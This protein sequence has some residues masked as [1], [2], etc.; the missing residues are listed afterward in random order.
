MIAGTGGGTASAGGFIRSAAAGR[1][2][3]V[4]DTERR[5]L[6]S[7]LFT[8]CR[9]A[10]A[11]GAASVPSGPS[12]KP[13]TPNGGTQRAG[14]A[15]TV[16]LLLLL[17]LGVL[18]SAS[19]SSS[20][21]NNSSSSSSSSWSRSDPLRLAHGSSA[22]A[23]MADGSGVNTRA[24]APIVAASS[25][26]SSSSSC[27][28]AALCAY[29]T[30]PG[31]WVSDAPA[32]LRWQLL[33]NPTCQ[34]RNLLGALSSASSST[35][36]AAAAGTAA[37]VGGSSSSAAAGSQQDT[38]KDRDEGSKDSVAEL[39]LQPLGRVEHQSGGDVYIDDYQNDSSGSSSSS[40]GSS[41]SSS[42][43][44]SSSSGSS[45]SSSSSS[46]HGDESGA[47]SAAAA[48]AAHAAVDGAGA[49]A[50]PRP[51]R[52]LLLSDSVDRF[53]VQHVCEH[54][55]GSKHTHA[56]LP[57][58]AA[59]AAEAAAAAA[60][61]EAAA[62]VGPTSTVPASAAGGEP[63]GRDGTVGPNPLNK[64]AYAFHTC[65]GVPGLQLASSYFPGVHPTGPFHRYAAQAYPLRIDTAAAMWAQY[66][67]DGAPPDAVSIAS[68]L[69]DVAR[70]YM[71]EPGAVEGVQELSRPLLEAWTANF[72]RV[73]TYA[74]AAFPQ[75]C[76]QR[77]ADCCRGAWM[78]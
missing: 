2:D 75:V 37:S 68:A 60:A 48:A 51:V 70:L 73:V 64:T 20:S 74:R 31:T 15:C 41:G 66:A 24:A 59:L 30:L 47:V 1:I 69:W 16:L 42:G 40:S 61:A 35:A 44:S 53:I 46:D 56:M 67:G 77:A 32:G 38:G 18:L 52:V 4:G 25:S 34:L 11:G 57:G 10:I 5:R 55:G 22:S 21:S 49:T 76:R 13:G 7:D 62:H 19:R 43:S 23:R 14:T 54:L 36:A 26:S 33:G 6:L 50:P 27:G 72:T 39:Q 71:H 65:S 28:S 8:P 12:R 58:P 17:L 78:L 29:G 45:G 63:P 9:A 3:A